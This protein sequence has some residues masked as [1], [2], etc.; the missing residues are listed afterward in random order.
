MSVLDLIFRSRRSEFGSLNRTDREHATVGGFNRDSDKFEAINVDSDGRLRIAGN[1]GPIE[2]SLVDATNVPTGTTYYPSSTGITMDDYNAMS[3]T[4]KIIEWDAADDVITI[5]V[6]NDEDID[7][8]DWVQVWGY[9]QKNDNMVDETKQSG[10][11]ILTFA[12]QF[13]QFN[14][15][16][17]RVK[18]VIGDSTNTIIIK[19]RR[20][21]L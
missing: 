3:L 18:L 4:G 15:S 17:F 10:A 7:N 16:Y 13:L 20:M 5:E 6:T 11:G 1:S 9:D 8:A 19:L 14:F 2:T 21:F 12:L